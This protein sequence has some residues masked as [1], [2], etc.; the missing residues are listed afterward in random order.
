MGFLGGLKKAFTAPNRMLGKLPGMQSVAKLPGMNAMMPGLRQSGKSNIPSAPG[1]GQGIGPSQVPMQQMGQMDQM[2][3]PAPEM[4][5]PQSMGGQMPPQM[6][7]QNPMIQ[8]KM[9]Q[10]RGKMGRSPGTGPGIGPS[11]FG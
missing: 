11:M 2:E 7:Q 10:L 1:I 9:M 4:M 8:Q 5:D 3:P 6:G